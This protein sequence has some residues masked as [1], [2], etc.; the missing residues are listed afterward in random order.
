MKR[1]STAV[2][3]LAGIILFTGLFY[4]GI[5]QS[6]GAH[7]PLGLASAAIPMTVPP[8][9][10]VFQFSDVHASANSKA[11]YMSGGFL[12]G[13]RYIVHHATVVELITKAYGFPVRNILG[14]PFWI[15]KDRY[16]V[17][18]Q[19]PSDASDDD[20]KAMLRNLLADRF[21]LVA[22][23]ENRSLAAYVITA[24][25][26]GAKMKQSEGSGTPGCKSVVSLDTTTAGAPVV[27]SCHAESMAAFA[28]FV[29]EINASTEPVVDHTGLNGLWDFK[30]KAIYPARTNV[31]LAHNF[32]AIGSWVGLN[33]G[34][35]TASL[36]VLIVDRVNEV[37][38]PNPPGVAALLPPPADFAIASL[39]PSSPDNKEPTGHIGGGQIDLT[40]ATMHFLINFA[41]DL[42]DHMIA[43]P[44][45][46]LDQAKFDI[47]ASVAQP[48]TKAGTPRAQPFNDEDLPQMVKKLLEER[49][50]MR[51]H[52]EDRPADAY[53]LLAVHPKMQPANPLYHSGC[54]EGPGPDGKDPRIAK[55]ILGRLISCQNMTM[56]QLAAELPVRSTGY[57]KL[58]MFD[59]TGLSGAY[60]FVVSF[61]GYSQVGGINEWSLKPPPPDGPDAVR[62]VVPP[63]GLLLSEAIEQQLGLKLEKQ[64]RPMPMLVIDH[65]NQIPREN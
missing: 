61:S 34:A 8:S 19:A 17:A 41:F 1:I 33:V 25:D 20:V 54:K 64:K 23:T 32:E 3:T 60:D 2:G 38:S 27:F 44:P 50:G 9:P 11:A 36:P 21:K 53:V 42:N 63:G 57:I 16:D 62:L 7:P 46:W 13:D 39:K 37:P 14:G 35:G 56:A 29:K 59:A 58:P 15:D 12:N 5:A 18:A 49:F 65:I 4:S 6:P 45:K 40:G 52:M 10:L 55:P 30:F 24:P 31:D 48:D 22:H 51:W 43:N 47:L 28:A 26:A